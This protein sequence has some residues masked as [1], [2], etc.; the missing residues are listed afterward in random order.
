VVIGPDDMDAMRPECPMPSGPD[1]RRMISAAA[2][3][4]WGEAGAAEADIQ[5]MVAEVERLRLALL[6]QCLDNL[7]GHADVARAERAEAAVERLRD[8]LD[9][10]VVYGEDTLSGPTVSPNDRKWHRDGVQEMTR[11]AR[12]A[13]AAD[14]DEGAPPMTYP[15][16]RPE[17]LDAL[18]GRLRATPLYEGSGEESE[19]PDDAADTIAALEEWKARAEA[20]EAAVE[21]AA[22]LALEQA[23][24]AA[25]KCLGHNQNRSTLPEKIE[26]YA[27]LSIRDAIRALDPAAIAA[28]AMKEPTHD[29]QADNSG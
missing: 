12:A 2:V 28:E 17:A 25:N 16:L 4:L 29:L 14:G 24:A 6:G 11:R 18:R 10:I 20:A 3:R 15:D 5:R 23:A 22:K 7:T 8:V 1:L 21:R 13:L 26:Y 27:A 9:G 19:L